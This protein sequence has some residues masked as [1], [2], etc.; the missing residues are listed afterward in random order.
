MFLNQRVL[1][2]SP[3]RLTKIILMIQ[4]LFVKAQVNEG[5]KSGVGNTGVTTSQISA[6]G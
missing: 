6:M 2:S 1:G 4:T 5:T 3:R